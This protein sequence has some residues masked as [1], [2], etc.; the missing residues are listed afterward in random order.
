MK[1]REEKFVGKLIDTMY[2]YNKE[3]GEGLNREEMIAGKT[4]DNARKLLKI[5]DASESPDPP[6]PDPDVTRREFAQ[7]DGMGIFLAWFGP[8]Y[9]DKE[10]RPEALYEAERTIAYFASLGISALNYFLFCQ[11][12]RPDNAYSLM[13]NPWIR[14]S[15][16]GRPYDL[17]RI[18][19]KFLACYEAFVEILFK[20]GIDP[21]VCLFMDRYNYYPFENNV[22]GVVSFWSSGALDYQVA[23][24][25]EILRIHKKIFG[26][27]YDHKIRTLNEGIHG[28]SHRRF[29]EISDLH[30]NLYE[31][32]DIHKL[33]KPRD[34][35]IDTSGCEA[36]MAEFVERH[37]CPKCR[38]GDT[39]GDGH[40]GS[41]K[42]LTADGRRQVQVINHGV[43]IKKNLTDKGFYG[44]LGSGWKP[45]S[46][47][48]LS[49][50]GGV[51]SENFPLANGYTLYSPTGR[52]IWKQGD[53]EETGD[54][55]FEI[56]SKSDERGKR[57]GY[58]IVL[59]ET[60][61]KQAVD[62]ETGEIIETSWPLKEDFRVE[63]IRDG[64]ESNKRRISEMISAHDRVFPIPA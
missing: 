14:T 9:W 29:H 30:L 34:Y 23:L 21:I 4:G 45:P 26:E 24:A 53:N 63:V 61:Q 15:G 41:T 55:T 47:L 43:G 54:L 48:W 44:W 31:Q 62:E 35:F 27:N 7:I 17:S 58:Q 57:S 6:D 1:D 50:D 38:P 64:T 39:I 12:N 42:Y 51:G 11:D 60:L 13:V 37:K 10:T 40:F 22:N 2:Q 59:F 19:P 3:S 56:Y 5:I 46:G 16:S 33:V 36:A 32:S 18:R 52:P 28:T 8:L 49:G 20:Y 25:D